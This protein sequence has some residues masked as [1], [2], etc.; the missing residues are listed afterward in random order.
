MTKNLLRMPVLVLAIC[1]L[2]LSSCSRQD[3]TIV[4]KLAHVL[5]T[6]H[7]VHQGM[8]YICL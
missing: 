7:A 1:C 6:G 8:L 2:A 3:D 4:L 5:D